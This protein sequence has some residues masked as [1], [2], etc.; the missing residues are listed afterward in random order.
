VPPAPMETRVQMARQAQPAPQVQMVPQDPP[1]PL[2]I[3][4]FKAQSEPEGIR[5]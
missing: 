3:K 1:A 4:D 2:A 5:F